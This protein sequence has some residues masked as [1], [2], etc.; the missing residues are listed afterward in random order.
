MDRQ[1][2]R[3]LKHD[4][5]VDEVGALSIRARENQRVLVTIAA[6]AVAVA[7]IAYGIYFYRSNRE[8]KAQ[9]ALAAAIETMS[10]PLIPTPTPGQP[11]QPP[12]PNA[13]YHTD[14][15]RIEA[16][17]KQFKEVQTKYAGS[18]AA[19]VANLYMARISANKGDTATA[20][21]LL[22]DFIGEHPKNILVG[23]ARYDLYQLRIDSGEAQ[24]VATELTQELTKTDNQ[25]L[26]PDAM[27]ALLAHAYDAQG[28]TD[29]SREAYRRI[30]TEY[31]D[32]SYVLEAQRRV[33]S[34]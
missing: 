34:A 4:R 31:P 27:L 22:Q 8:Q 21:K 12:M 24:Q 32:S 19:D 14:A 3:E 1:H 18:D 25:A 17:S 20:K 16:A 29:K 33:G 10:S 5:F 30:V 28:S 13:K 15:E 9:D 26:P 23:V 7:L 11:P 2:R 6:A